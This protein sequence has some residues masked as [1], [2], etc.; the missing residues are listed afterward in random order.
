[1]LG[2]TGQEDLAALEIDKEQHIEPTE[3]DH[4]DV[5]KVTR[6]RAGRLGAKEL[7][8]GRS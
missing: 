7:R 6:Q 4:V 5:E 3:R 1:V 2:D 8:P